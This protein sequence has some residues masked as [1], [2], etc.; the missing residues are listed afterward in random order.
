MRWFLP[1]SFISSQPFNRPTDILLEISTF[2]IAGHETTS[3]STAWALFELSR[4]PVVQDRLRKE[5]LAVPTGQ[6][7]M[8]ELN[9]LPYLESFVKE[10]LRLYSPVPGTSRVALK[11]DVIPLS[12]PIQDT[13]G[14]MLSEIR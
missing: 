8:E 11:D 13:Q 3:T 2:L 12:V 5:L 7:T 4:N 9:A 1:V 10:V 14:N 6:P